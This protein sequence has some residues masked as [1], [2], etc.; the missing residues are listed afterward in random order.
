MCIQGSEISFFL[1]CSKE[2]QKSYMI[3]ICVNSRFS[4]GN[5]RKWYSNLF[6]SVLSRYNFHHGMTVYAIYWSMWFLSRAI[7]R[8]I[9]ENVPI[10]YLSFFVLFQIN[11]INRRYDLNKQNLFF[12]TKNWINGI[13]L[14]SQLLRLY[15]NIIEYNQYKRRDKKNPYMLH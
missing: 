14:I 12:P 13:Q 7:V 5:R 2:R 1:W 8:W 6:I 9:A 4:E 15:F 10:K 3:L 11:Y